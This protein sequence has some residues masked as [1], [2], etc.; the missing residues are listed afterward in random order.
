[1]IQKPF[2]TFL[3]VCLCFL[4]IGIDAVSVVNNVTVSSEILSEVFFNEIRYNRDL[5]N[6]AK[7]YHNSE[8]CFRE[9]S[10]IIKKPT[11]LEVIPFFDSWG[12]FPSGILY[13]NVYDIGNFDQC[14]R[15]SVKF[16]ELPDNPVNGQF[17]FARV[18]LKNLE[19]QPERRIPVFSDVP[20]TGSRASLSELELSI[21]ICVP[22]SCSAE[23]L[24]D[25]LKE[26]LGHAGLQEAL[27]GISVHWCT[28]GKPPPYKAI[29][30][31]GIVIFGVFGVLMVLSSLYEYFMRL[32]KKTPVPVLLAFS[33][34][35]NGRK[36]FDINTKSS[37][38]TINCL[39]GIRVISMA[40]IMSCHTY[41]TMQMIP[42]INLIESVSWF[43]NVYS[44]IF[45]NGTVAVDSFFFIGG[46]LVAWLGFREMDKTNGKLNI[47]MMYVHRYIRLTPLVAASLLY[48]FSIN[49]II[50]TGPFREKTLGTDNCTPENW[51]PILLYIQNYFIQEP[52]CFARSW[53]LAI[54]F[55]LYLFAP[56]LLLA[57][58]KWGKKFFAVLLVLSLMSIACVMTIFIANGFTNLRSFQNPNEWTK[59]YIPMHTRCSPWLVGFGLGYFMHIN[60]Q[61][62]FHLSKVFQLLAWFVSAFIMIAV[63]F[64]PYFTMSTKGNGTVFEA[65]MYE[66]WK[67]FSWAIALAW[68]TFACQIGIGGTVDAFLSHPY[69][70]PFAKLTYSLYLIHSFVLRVNFGMMRTEIFFSDY[71][72]VLYFWNTFGISMMVAIISTLA[73]ESPILILEKFIFGGSSSDKKQTPPPS[74]PAIQRVTFAEPPQKGV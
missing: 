19:D 8:K 43:K 9:L 10:E 12:K 24:T 27:S 32:F 17:C 40:W 45:I 25:V 33:I 26:G 21:G 73:F 51:W 67:R 62:K 71:N 65:A 2:L 61:R 13:G 28:D 46:L 42:A 34:L 64:G 48:T 56:F 72:A 41:M 20:I 47:V 30:I 58:R 18:P 14:V 37:P 38:N 29:H 44:M 69:W 49:E 60:R 31:I 63:V 11:S 35:T 16:S 74:E 66:G 7:L 4:I 54:D 36:L 1:M 15:T 57:M 3:T 52:Q 6:K 50:F 70:Q 55:Q 5:I 23:F 59:T 53:Y 39:T 68:I 22:D